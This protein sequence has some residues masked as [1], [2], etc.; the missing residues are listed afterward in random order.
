MPAKSTVFAWLI[1][2]PEFVIMYNVAREMQAEALVDEIIEISDDGQ[3]D[4]AKDE[5]G[6]DRVD[7]DHI[8]RARL[9]VDSRKWFASKMRPKKYG[10][11]LELSGDKNAPVALIIAGTDKDG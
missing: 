7:Y 11:K 2:H 1:K 5:D 3:R 9:R 10:E 6:R 4:Y 8:S